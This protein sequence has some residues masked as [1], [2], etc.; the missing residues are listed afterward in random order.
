MFNRLYAFMAGRNGFDRLGIIS[1]VAAIVLKNVAW[2]FRNWL[3]GALNLVS[4]ALFGYTAFRV[5]SRNVAKR[6]SENYALIHLMD[7]LRIWGSN[8]RTRH[9]QRKQYKFFTCPGCKNKLR[10]PRGKGRIQ[11]TCPRCGQRFGGKT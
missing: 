7:H 8:C 1:L 5:L 2:F 6:R 10:V 3:Y 11:I 4:L 9:A